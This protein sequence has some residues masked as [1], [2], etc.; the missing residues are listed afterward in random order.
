MKNLK[1]ILAVSILS[2]GLFSTNP[3]LANENILDNKTTTILAIN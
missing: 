2:L 1:N 3:A